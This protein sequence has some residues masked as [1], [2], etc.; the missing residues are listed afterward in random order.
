MKKKYSI[1]F[2]GNSYT[3]YNDMPCGIFQKFAE[4]AGLCVEV[5]TITKGGWTLEKFSDPSDEHGK[6]ATDALLSA[7]YG[8]YD[9][10][11]LQEQSH[12]PVTNPEAFHT[13]AKK[14]ISMVK[15][16]GATPL[17][18]STWGRKSGS[19]TLEEYNLTNESM[20]IGLAKAY[21][22]IANECNIDVAHTGLA[23]FDIYTAKD[24]DIE[25]YNPDA[26]HPSYAGSYLAAAVLFG[27]VFGISP[28]EISFRGELPPADAVLLCSAADRALTQKIQ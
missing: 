16:I 28:K 3:Y 9:F 11:I 15:N 5:K 2:I 20:T 27:K 19:P 24:N 1:L 12:Q 25:L 22:S 17:L 14:L 26:S 10:I 23:F 7:K 4:S 13:A 6:R 21:Q 18:Y 8:E